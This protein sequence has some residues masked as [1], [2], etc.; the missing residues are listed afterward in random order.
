[1]EDY[2][3][4]VCGQLNFICDTE[5]QDLT[6]DDK[7]ELFIN[8]RQAFGRT[9]LLLSGGA[10]LGLNHF[11]VIKSLNE[12]GLLPRIVSG[13]SIG[14]LVAAYVC[15]KTDSEL[16]TALHSEQLNLNALEAPD[17]EG[18]FFHKLSRF[19]K[20]GTLANKRLV[21]KLSL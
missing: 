6:L 13:S 15:T 3:D 18:N 11:G 17:E 8:V 21:F 9:A 19:I 4:E 20:H 7:L 10:T 14:S 16:F 5:T 12:C 1:M 2:I